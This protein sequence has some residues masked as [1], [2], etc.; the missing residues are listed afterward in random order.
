M[1][2]LVPP[3]TSERIIRIREIADALKIDDST[4]EIDA[5]LEDGDEAGWGVSWKGDDRFW[6][7]G[8]TLDEALDG[9]IRQTSAV[10]G[11]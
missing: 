7:C 6:V 5:P 3:T 2:G 8:P 11:I 4:L 9:F 1:L 10:R